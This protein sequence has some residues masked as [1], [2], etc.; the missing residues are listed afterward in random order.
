VSD[1]DQDGGFPNGSGSLNPI[2]LIVPAIVLLAAVV[3]FSRRNS[4]GGNAVEE[5]GK[6][7]STAGKQT[8][9]K[10]G[11]ASRRAMLTLAINAL[12]NDGAR[13]AVIMGL[14]LV[15]SRS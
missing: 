10:G 5:V 12:E 1:F 9:R 3:L 14:K 4:G 8:G 6:A 15:R 13:R 2:A 7:A 11:S